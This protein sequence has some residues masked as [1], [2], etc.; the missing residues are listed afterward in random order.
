MYD[1]ADVPEPKVAIKCKKIVHFLN[2]NI[3]CPHDVIFFIITAD[4]K[5]IKIALAR[6]ISIQRKTWMTQI[7]FNSYAVDTDEHFDVTLGIRLMAVA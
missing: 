5:Q 2:L 4:L 7:I 6:T 1:S 3:T